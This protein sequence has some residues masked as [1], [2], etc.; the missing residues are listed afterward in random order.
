MSEASK[1]PVV[2][3]VMS[4]Y[5]AE[6]YLNKAIES[7]LDQTF[8]DFEFIIIED[9]ST[10]NSL[11]IIEDY[12]SKDSRINLIKKLENKGTAGFI[13]NLNIGI[14]KA[15]GRYIARM[16]ADDISS[17][18]RFEKQINFLNDNPA[19]DLIGASIELID[20]RDQHIEI[21]KAIPHH[22]DIVKRMPKKISLYHP[23]I[24]FRKESTKGYRN[25][26]L[27][28][29]DY[30]MYFNMIFAGRKFANLNEVLLK[31]RILKT[32]ISRKK[33]K[34]VRWLFVE[35]IRSF[36]NENVTKGFDSY[37]QFEPNDFIDILSLDYN[38]N[39]QDLVFALKSSI[40]FNTIEETDILL[41][42]IK[43]QYPKQSLLKYQLLNILPFVVKKYLIKKID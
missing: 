23:V 22:N 21:W 12:A 8:T 34:F 36:Y 9:C 30:D 28:C 1:T 2:S 15:N 29:E 27:F 4:V 32:S 11:K 19:I 25:K 33:N 7:I 17:N 3:V 37:S 24:M 14:E 38:N 26:A 35:K 41:R 42:K 31:Y 6:K 20:E 18:T 43:L 5:N 40:I 10:D 16:D 39:L 13:E